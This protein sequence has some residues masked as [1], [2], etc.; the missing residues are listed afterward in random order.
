MSQNIVREVISGTEAKELLI[1]AV[2]KTANIVGDTL[3]YRGNNNIFEKVG[4]LPFITK[5]GRNSINELFWD[6]SIEAIALQILKEASEKTFEEAGDNTT[7]TIVLTQAFFKNSY[8]SVKSGKS[9]IDVKNEIDASVKKVVD[10][11][12]GISVPLTEKLMYD[13]AKT[14]ANHDEEIAKL[15]VEAYKKAG[16]HGIVSHKRI[17]DDETYVDF[18]DGN[19]IESGYASDA[20]IT[21]P[22]SQTVVFSDPLVLLS[23]INFQTIDE[24]TPFLDY[25]IKQGRPLVI[26][27]NMTHDISNIIETNAKGMN[28][29]QFKFPFA[30]IKPPYVGKLQKEAMSDLGL[31]LGCD[32]LSGIT[33]TNYEGKEKSFLGTCK[34]ISIDKKDTVITPSEEV[35]QVPVKTKIDELLGNISNMKDVDK[36]AIKERIARITGGISTIMVGGITPSEID[37][38]V[39]RVDDAICAVRSAKEGVLA[40]GGCAFYYASSEKGIDEVTKKTLKA[41]LNKILLNAGLDISVFENGKSSSI[42]T[43]FDVKEFEMVDMFESG[44]VDTYKGLSNALINAASASNNLLLTNNVIY[45]KRIENGK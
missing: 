3:G 24:V 20:Y 30:V 33:R 14:S 15:V 13:V 28:K 25:A 40:G 42:N 10:Y 2:D 38:K 8:D 36:V 5:D 41:P 43:G 18:I 11:L 1:K 32:V 16:E 35:D 21:N 27:A 6:N 45:L 23:L 12:K 7:N 44:I 31:V 19:P 4:G 26:V 29:E 22:E 9:P 39:D 37:E 17:F 34:R